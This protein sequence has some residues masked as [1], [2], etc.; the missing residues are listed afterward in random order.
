[1]GGS[2]GGALVILF[3]C[4]CVQDIV[5]A[6]K[7]IQYSFV[8]AIDL[9]FRIALGQASHGGHLLSTTTAN[10]NSDP[11]AARCG[12]SQLRIPNA[13]W[14]VSRPGVRFHPCWW[15]VPSPW[16][17]KSL[18]IQ[19]ADVIYST[20]TTNTTTIATIVSVPPSHPK[21]LRK[22][23]ISSPISLITPHYRCRPLSPTLQR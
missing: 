22:H 12:L 18:K 6:N 14:K 21:V 15:R 16:Y 3:N 9:R 4:W 2:E 20:L 23:T 8:V 1:M 7:V 19:G 17:F 11:I 10:V 5:A 13:T